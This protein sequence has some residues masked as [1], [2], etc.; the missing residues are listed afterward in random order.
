MRPLVGLTARADGRPTELFAMCYL[1]RMAASYGGVDPH[2]RIL[3]DCLI[4][5]T[6]GVRPESR[7]LDLPLRWRHAWRSAI[8]TRPLGASYGRLC[9]VGCESLDGP[10]SYPV[11]LVR[12][13]RL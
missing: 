5:S 11:V 9:G 6:G 10:R 8:P 12:P 1:A 2:A 3:F 4:V 7:R 13:A